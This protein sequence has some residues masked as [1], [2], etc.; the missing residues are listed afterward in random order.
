M[1][2]YRYKLLTPEGKVSSG[3]VKLQYQETMSAINYL[4]RDGHITL[5]VAKLGRMG[6]L[7]RRIMDLRPPAEAVP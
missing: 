1:N 7:L 5:F 4:E 6:R 2:Y 3:V